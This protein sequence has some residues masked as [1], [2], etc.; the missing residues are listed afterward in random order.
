MSWP[1]PRALGRGV[2]PGG[3]GTRRA[4]WPDPGVEQHAP[5]APADL[6]VAA[7]QAFPLVTGPLG[8]PD[9]ARVPGLD[10]EL[11]PVQRGDGPP[12]RGQ[13]DQRRRREAAAPGARDERV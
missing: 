4:V 11:D 1:Y 2:T 12:E 13:R 10:V 7:Q 8:G 3:R 5:A 9:R 6:L